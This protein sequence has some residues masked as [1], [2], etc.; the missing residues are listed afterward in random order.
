MGAPSRSAPVT[1]THRPHIVDTGAYAFW[2]P[3]ISQ[4]AGIHALPHHVPAARWIQ[5]HL[6]AGASGRARVGGFVYVVS[7]DAGTNEGAGVPERSLALHATRCCK[8]CGQAVTWGRLHQNFA[9][10]D[11]CRLHANHVPESH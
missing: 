8:T 4:R 5:W 7:G 3:A 2:K 6:I 9:G 11:S 10:N 1:R